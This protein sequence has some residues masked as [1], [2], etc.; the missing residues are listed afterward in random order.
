M[1][2]LSI[3]QDFNVGQQAKDKS[4]ADGFRIRSAEFP[5]AQNA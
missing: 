3:G 4:I 2:L 1:W 5:V